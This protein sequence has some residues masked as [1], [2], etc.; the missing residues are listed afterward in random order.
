MK[1]LRKKFGHGWNVYLR[2]IS[3][4]KIYW[5]LFVLGVVG[6]IG[7]SAIDAG[8]TWLIKPIINKG[9]VNKD[10]AFISTLPIIVVLIFL[11]RGLS[12][13]LSNYCINRVSRNVVRDFRRKLFN[14][15]MHMP[16]S[17]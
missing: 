5:L 7:L 11:F 15:L 6:T 2:L 14:H 16:A 3:A 8:F 4:A 17:Y 10:I 9:F 1:F 13:F 12:G